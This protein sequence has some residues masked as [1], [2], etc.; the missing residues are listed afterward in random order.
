MIDAVVRSL[1]SANMGWIR[2]LTGRHLWVEFVDLRDISS[3]L[4]FSSAIKSPDVPVD[5]AKAN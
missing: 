5:D 3:F 4:P 2:C 1:P